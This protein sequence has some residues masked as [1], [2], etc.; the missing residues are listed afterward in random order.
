MEVQYIMIL[1]DFYHQNLF[2][3]LSPLPGKPYTEVKPGEGQRGLAY[4]DNVLQKPLSRG[5]FAE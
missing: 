3:E 2:N 1:L 4:Y 5:S